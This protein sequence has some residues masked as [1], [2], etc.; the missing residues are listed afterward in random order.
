MPTLPDAPDQVLPPSPRPPRGSR[1]WFVWLFASEGLSYLSY[2]VL[3]P[4]IVSY[5]VFVLGTLGFIVV[6]GLEA[7]ESLVEAIIAPLLQ[8][9]AQYQWIDWLYDP[10]RTFRANA[11]RTFGLISVVGYLGRTL[12]LRLRGRAPVQLPFADRLRRAA[13]RLGLFT[14]A[15]VAGMALAVM[16]A[17]WAD[18]PPFW[19]IVLQS[20]GISAAM[21]GLIYVASLPPLAMAHVLREG[22]T[23]VGRW[24][25]R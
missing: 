18:D 22:R 13:L 6:S 1:R 24:I 15:L 8:L 7:N 14:A 12:W 2:L 23:Y 5:A 11:L 20:V 19:Q 21:G 10:E 16:T 25:S 4:V 9:D 3:A 17:P